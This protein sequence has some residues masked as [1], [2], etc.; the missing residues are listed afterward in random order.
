MRTVS[1]KKLLKKFHDKHIENNLKKGQIQIKEDWIGYV[2]VY[3]CLLWHSWPIRSQV[4]TVKW[5]LNMT[6]CPG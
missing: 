3:M 2:C 5:A 1:M 6:P 4:L